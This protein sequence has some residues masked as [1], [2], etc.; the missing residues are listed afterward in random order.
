VLD[1]SGIA[2][3]TLIAVI[4]SLHSAGML[5]LCTNATPTP[6]ELAELATE[7]IFLPTALSSLAA[8]DGETEEPQIAQ[9]ALNFAKKLRLSPESDPLAREF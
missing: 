9:E 7:S 1:A 5:V 3:S 4:S 8:G 6:Q 2:S